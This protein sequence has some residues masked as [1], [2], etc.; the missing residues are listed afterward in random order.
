MTLSVVP[1]PGGNVSLYLFLAA[2]GI[3]SGGSRHF[4]LCVPARASAAAHFYG[5]CLLWLLA[6]SFSF[7]GELDL[8]DHLYFCSTAS[9][10][11]L[12]PSSSTSPSPS[13][14]PAASRALAQVASL[15]YAPS[16]ALLALSLGSRLLYFSPLSPGPATITGSEIV[17]DRLEPVLWAIYSLAAFA[18]FVDA[19]RN[20]ESVTVSKQ[21][22]WIVWVPA[23]ECFRSP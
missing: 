20:A 18:A 8:F 7:T 9:A 15:V 19:Y 11:S 6:F 13:R 4:R 21:L 10:S 12:P 17:L 1:L 3:F 23:P 22:K 2:V 5:L 16:F 14:T